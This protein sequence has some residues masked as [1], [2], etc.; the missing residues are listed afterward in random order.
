VLARSTVIAPELIRE[1]A[2]SSLIKSS[3]T[4]STAINK[5]GPYICTQHYRRQPLPRVSNA[6]G[7][8]PKTLGEPPWMPLTGKRPSPSAKSRTLGEAFPEC[9]PSTQERFD[10]AGVVHLF[11]LKPLP[12][13]QHSGKEF[14][15]FYKNPLPRVQ[16]SGK[17]FDFFKKNLLPRVPHPKHSGKSMS[18]FFK[19]QPFPECPYLGTRGSFF[20][21]F[22]L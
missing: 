21:C 16:H 3:V 4:L 7:K 18:H 20:F 11:F 9:R 14:I 22:S 15:F 10:A 1:L 17:K 13:V 2:N 6:L 19:K 12:Q 8:C 5:F